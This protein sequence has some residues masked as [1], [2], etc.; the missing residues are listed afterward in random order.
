M[1]QII[2]YLNENNVKI[3]L[4]NEFGKNYILRILT[5][6]KYIGV[7]TYKGIEKPDSI[8]RIIDDETFKQAQI[9]LEKNKKA[10]ARAKA[11]EEMYL[12][13]TKIFCGHC[14]S[15]IIGVSGTSRN[16]KVHQYY[17]CSNNRKKK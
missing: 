3:A 13:S 15:S 14:K 8:S 5:N 11:K 7:Y 17:Q 10:P 16:R 9:M 4:G 12:L 1:A 2:R 6:K